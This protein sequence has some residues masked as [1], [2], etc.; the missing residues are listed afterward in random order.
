M[1]LLVHIKDRYQAKY[2]KSD[3]LEKAPDAMSYEFEQQIIKEH[4]LV[5]VPCELERKFLDVVHMIL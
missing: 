5:R 2:K 4:K 3:Q 1:Q